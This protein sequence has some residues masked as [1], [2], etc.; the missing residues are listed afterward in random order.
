[1]DISKCNWAKINRGI[2]R[3]NFTP[4]V[5]GVVKDFNFRSLSQ[6]VEPQMFHQFA[7]YAP[8]KFFVRIKPGNPVN[9]LA[10]IKKAWERCVP[11]MPF[12]YDFVD[13]ELNKFYKSEQ[14]WSSNCRMGRRY[15]YF[16]CMPWFIWFG[17]SCCSKPYKRNWY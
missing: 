6:P 3:Q 2:V 14:R 7:S 13:E 10:E 16:S 11:E 12:K 1:M 5:I 15:F 17:N 4:V 8:Y 9:A